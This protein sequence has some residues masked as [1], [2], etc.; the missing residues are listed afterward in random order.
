MRSHSQRHPLDP[1]AVLDSLIDL[2]DWME[3]DLFD[4]RHDSSL[5]L[6]DADW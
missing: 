1:M 2:P 6:E 4:D 5:D 3:A